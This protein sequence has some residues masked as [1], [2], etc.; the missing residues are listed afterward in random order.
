MD[1]RRANTTPFSGS[2]IPSGP[3]NILEVFSGEGFTIIPGPTGKTFNVFFI[4]E[5]SGAPAALVELG[6]NGAQHSFKPGQYQL[7]NISS[8]GLSIYYVVGESQSIKLGW[9]YN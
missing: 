9:I 4:Y 6:Y 3:Q 7:N 5:Y 8:D 1:D 2:G